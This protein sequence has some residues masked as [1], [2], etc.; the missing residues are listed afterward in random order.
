MVLPKQRCRLPN[1]GPCAWSEA[2]ETL[3]DE[4]RELAA[5]LPSVMSL[6]RAPRTVLKYES[7][8]Q[9]WREWAER[10]SVPSLPAD[11]FHVA[12]YL[13]YLLQEARTA[14]PI[15][16]AMCSLTWFHCPYGYE[17][18][19]SNMVV[20]NVLQA[21]RRSLGRPKDRKQPLT[22]HLLQKLLNE[23]SSYSLQD[24][25]TLTLMVLGYAGMLRWDDLSNIHV[26]EIIVKSANMAVF[27]EV[28]K[29]DQF[30]HGSWVF[31]S[32]W[33]GELCPVSL[34]EQLLQ[35]GKQQGHVKLFGRIRQKKGRQVIRSSLSYSRARELVRDA[36]TR[37]GVNP[38]DY[39]LQSLRSGGASAAAAAGVPDR[40]IQCQGGCRATQ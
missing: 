14:S 13:V 32:R 15:V 12:L 4:M 24:H 28:R 23:L 5:D 30:R 3:S 40:L 33:E 20:K 18:P 6:S 19:C 38:N 25:Q 8:F 34:V 10:Q 35:K 1:A 21:A 17:D 31:I 26:D 2:V 22:K 36:L 11:S 16:A 39:G 9:R 37:I 7:G 29:N 27:L